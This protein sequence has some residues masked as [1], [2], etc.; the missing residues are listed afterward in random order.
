[1]PQWSAAERLV[2]GQFQIGQQR[3]QEE[4]AAGRLVE[5]QRV[6]ADPA[7]AGELREFAFQ[8]RRRIDDAASRLPPEPARSHAI[9]CLSRS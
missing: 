7:E 2:V 4:V 6:L 9:S 5:Q 8:E 1:M 3:R